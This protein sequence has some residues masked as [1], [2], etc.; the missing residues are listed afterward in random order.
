MP[1]VLLICYLS[2]AVA[3]NIISLQPF[4]L[5]SAAD[6]DIRRRQFNG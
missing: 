4:S 2:M 3:S 6:F 5:I 1:H